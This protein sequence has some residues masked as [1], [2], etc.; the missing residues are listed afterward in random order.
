MP[1][2]TRELDLHGTAILIGLSGFLG[3]NQVLVKLVNVGMAPVF[4]V[5]LR[6]ACAFL[7]VL[8]WSLW[9]RKRLSVSDGSLSLGLLNGVFFSLEF[10]LLF[11]ALEYTSVAR[12]SLFFYTMPFWVALGAHFLLPGQSINKYQLSGLVLAGLGVYL[13]FSDIDSQPSPNAWIGDCLSIAAAICW[14]AIALLTR[15]TRLSSCTPE[16]LLLYQLGFSAI[17]LTAIAV[18]SGDTFREMDLTI[19]ALFSFQVIFIAS[20]SFIAWFWAL[21]VYPI[22]SVASFGLLTPVFGVFFGWVLLDDVVTYLLLLALV[23]IAG[24]LVLVNVRPK[25]QTPIEDSP[26]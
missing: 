3:L 6:S 14:A 8:A 19:I 24:G 25:A 22:N 10:C 4:Q 9:R 23:L 12:V 17:V 2:Y 21:S 16:M 11:T 26:A 18:I 5:G 20:F 15:A 7:P 13:V 1:H